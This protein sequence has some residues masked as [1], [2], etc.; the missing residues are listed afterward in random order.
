MTR[1]KT[2]RP[3][4]LIETMRAQMNDNLRGRTYEHTDRD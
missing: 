1:G 2:K 4:A 3:R